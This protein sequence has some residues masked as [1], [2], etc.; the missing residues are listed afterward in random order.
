[1]LKV[2]FQIRLQAERSKLF[3]GD[4]DSEGIFAGKGYIRGVV[5][6]SIGLFN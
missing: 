6:G 3:L 4:D 1:M 2:G 5:N